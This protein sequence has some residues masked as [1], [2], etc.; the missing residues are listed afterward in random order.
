[1]MNALAN[2]LWQSTLFACMIGLLTVLLSRNRSAVRYGL[3]LAASVKFLLPFSLL[4]ALGS[5]IQWRRAPAIDQPE[6]KSMQQ[7]SQPLVRLA[8]PARSLPRNS[9][10]PITA[11]L[12]SFWLCG[13]A[14]TSISG[15]RR[16][17]QVRASLRSA[18]PLALN[19]PIKV[20]SSR[21]HLE[22]GIFGICRPILLLPEGL[23]EHLSQAQFDTIIAHELCHVRRYDNLTFAI[24]SIVEALFWFYPPLHW[25]GKRLIEERES[26]CDEDVLRMGGNPQDYAEGI[27]TVCRFYIKSPLA[28]ASGIT[29]SDL[30]RRVEKIMLNRVGESMDAKRKLSLFVAAAAAVT[31]PLAIGVVDAPLFGAQEPEKPLPQLIATADLPQFEVAAIKP[32]PPDSN[33]RVDFAPGG[34]LYINH[35]TLRFLIKIAYDIG[36]DQLSG[37]PRWIGSKRFDVSAI[38]D[39]PVG[40]DPSNM[41]PSQILLFHKPTRLRLQRLLADRFQLELRKESVPMSIFALVVAKGGPKALVATKSTAGPQLNATLGNGRLD[42]VGMDMASLAKFLSEG[43]TGRPVVDMTGLKNKYDFRLDWSP[44]SKPAALPSASPADQQPA[45]AQDLSIFSAL[46]Q[47]LGLK[48]V[49]RSSAADRLIVVHAELPSAN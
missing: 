15:W 7:V 38:P 3:W 49:P 37:G 39:T 23:R 14:A 20:L 21:L 6:I 43:Q 29:G 8:S 25:I 24:H 2:H 11:I 40:G 31:L 26:A 32:S 5:Q 30:T 44:D 12:F 41:A 34:K 17:R 45:Y 48:L 36:D 13:F 46:Q 28:C 33:L 19:L 35:A 1:M 47:Q 27:V 4:I 16:W 22:P 9:T 10:R 18:S 42:A